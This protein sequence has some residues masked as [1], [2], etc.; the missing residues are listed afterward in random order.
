MVTAACLAEKGNHVICTDL[1]EEK[2]D[3]LKSGKSPIYEPGLEE[4][5]QNNLRNGRLT[6]T[7]SQASYSSAD[8][9]FICVGTPENADGSANLNYV[10]A[11]VDEIGK[12]AKKEAYVVIK[13]T[14]PVGTNKKMEQVLNEF[15]DETERL[16][17]ISNPEFLSQGSAIK[18][19]L[20]GSRIILG[21][22]S[23]ASELKMREVYKNFDQPII[24]TDVASAEMI[25]YASND[26]LALKISFM[27]DIANLCEKLGA[28]IDKVAEG[29]GL[30]PRIGP[31][32]LKAGV[33]YGGSCFPKDTKALH[34]LAEDQGYVLK[35]VKAAIEVNEKQK[36]KLVQAAKK[37]T[38]LRNKKIAV[39]GVTFKANTDDLRE[40]PAIA[41]IHMLLDEGANVTVFDP[42]GMQNTK[43]LLGNQISYAED[44]FGCI[45][46]A[47]LCF[48]FTDWLEFKQLSA[49]DFAFYMKHPVIYD[50]RNCYELEQM[51]EEGVYYYS[52]GRP[53]I[54]R[55]NQK[56]KIKERVQYA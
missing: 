41:N 2:M 23:K 20:S 44:M 47:D 9:L 46:D 45:K 39:L 38:E 28:N 54:D 25:K 55:R 3:I 35:T 6:F 7:T 26:Y 48:I 43:I 22:Q 14:V 31:Q 5:L 50:G 21:T 8:I 24:N 36:Y 19:T 29:M 51:K 33:G 34:W 1:N 49:K 4:L 17:V 40:S 30:D 37:A 42:V 10:Y 11:V 27:N 13:S 18:D 32:F 16:E 53:V 56:G 52:V 12:K 15:R